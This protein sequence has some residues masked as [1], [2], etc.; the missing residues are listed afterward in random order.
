MKPLLVEMQAFGPFAGRQVVDFKLLGSKT[1]F[2]I[3]GPTGSGKTTILDAICFA[4]FGDSSGGERE[5]HDMRS[6][7]ADAATLTEVSFDFALGD[8]RFRVHR[9]PDQMRKAKRG[10][11]E[12]RQPQSA[13]FFRVEQDG[14][15][16]V[17]QPIETG[18]SKVTTAVEA[19]LGFES[20]QF[21]QVI[22]LPQGK[23]FEFLKSSSQEREKIL[24]TLFGT[25]LYK[26][27]E[28]RLSRAAAE[29]AREAEVMK[30][31]RQTLLD[32]ANA[33]AEAEVEDR[34][35]QQASELAARRSAELVAAQAAQA[36]ERTLTEARKLADRFDE[37]DK[38]AKAL[39]T[40]QS[41]EPEWTS[42]TAQLVRARQAA[43]IQPYAAAVDELD[44]HLADEAT[45][46]RE[47]T[48]Q[49]EATAKSQRSA[50]DTL[51]KERLRAPETDQLIT[52]VAALEALGAKVTALD[53]A[54]RDNG[55]AVADAKR[56]QSAK[57]TA[58]KAFKDAADL[59]KK[60]ASEIQDLR[61]RS[62]SVEGLRGAEARLKQQLDQ[63]INLAKVRDELAKA[64]KLVDER[65]RIANTAQQSTASAKQARENIHHAWLAGQAARLA[66]EL[67]AGEAC[68]VCGA[69][70]HP[71]PAHFDGELVLDDTLKSAEDALGRG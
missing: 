61:V 21:R 9:I 67:V 71:A 23:F 63:A 56:A 27:I 29:V 46:Y 10:D 2:L 11:G 14:E 20:R 57:A 19:L 16:V 54:R 3:H 39:Q 32:Q 60:L 24:Q 62:A 15:K 26:R 52:R 34:L 8:Q 18:W 69:H 37:F 25:E 22:M 49:E 65:A 48:L 43:T 38:A 28:D 70:D 68:P 17:E 30:T 66:R 58:D 4:L 42:K 53:A 36:A 5:G 41:D 59:Q 35:V 45:R 1:F 7:H 13:E 33:G 47:L 55:T 40:L 44:R 50:D 31:K 6:D 12:A 51:N 64:V